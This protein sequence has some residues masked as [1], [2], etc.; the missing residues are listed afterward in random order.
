MGNP[1]QYQAESLRLRPNIRTGT[2]WFLTKHYGTAQHVP[3]PNSQN[4]TDTLKH[5]NGLSNVVNDK[6]RYH[7]GTTEN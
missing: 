4:N 5:Q 7:Y 3:I 2:R 1:R 6:G